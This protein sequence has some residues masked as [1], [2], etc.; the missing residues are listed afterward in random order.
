MYIYMSYYD[1]YLKYKN[2]YLQLKKQ[3]GGECNVEPLDEED[4]VDVISYENLFSPDVHDTMRITMRGRCYNIISLYDWHI[5]RENRSLP[6]YYGDLTDNEIKL[7]KYNYGLAISYLFTFYILDRNRRLPGMIEDLSEVKLQG[8]KENF[9]NFKNYK[10]C[11]FTSNGKRYYGLSINR[12]KIIPFDNIYQEIPYRECVELPNV[13]SLNR[14]AI[15]ILRNR[16][17]DYVNNSLGVIV[18]DLD[19]NNKYSVLILNTIFWI[20]DRY[21]RDRGIKLS[22]PEAISYKQQ[23]GLQN[24]KDIIKIPVLKLLANQLELL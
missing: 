14:G 10:Y 4:R 16:D 9:K 21:K 15:V 19:I 18:E 5:I 8:I 23:Y 17:L 6:G 7:I 2:K 11:S 1:K 22:P 13:I 3:K 12:K 24:N 20:Y